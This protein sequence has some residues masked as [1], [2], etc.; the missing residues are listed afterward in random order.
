VDKAQRPQSN[1]QSHEVVPY[2]ATHPLKG[3]AI[4]SASVAPFL[5]IWQL[6]TRQPALCISRF[7]FCDHFMHDLRRKYVSAKTLADT[8]LKILALPIVISRLIFHNWW[9]DHLNNSSDL[10]KTAGVSHALRKLIA[11]LFSPIKWVIGNWHLLK[12]PMDVN[13]RGCQTGRD[14][15]ALPLWLNRIA[16]TGSGLTSYNH[17]IARDQKRWR[18]FGFEKRFCSE[19]KP[20]PQEENFMNLHG[21]WMAWNF[22]RLMYPLIS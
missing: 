22:E 17:G 21:N 9:L 2:C 4:Y 20:R 7:H 13:R 18:S 11:P 12:E 5:V 8:N 1:D 10:L 6:H 15:R 19:R 16:F 14:L 3:T